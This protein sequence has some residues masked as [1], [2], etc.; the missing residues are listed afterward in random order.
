MP[1]RAADLPFNMETVA[2]MIESVDRFGGQRTIEHSV[3]LLS[4]LLE[5][6]IALHRSGALNAV[7][8]ADR[9]VL[10]AEA[11]GAL[12]HSKNVLMMASDQIRARLA[13]AP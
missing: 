2:K 5:L 11:P 10:N 3:G 1:G 4:I 13:T 7:E 12:P 6:V 9:L 8:L